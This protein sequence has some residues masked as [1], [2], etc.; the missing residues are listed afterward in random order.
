M[1]RFNRLKLKLLFNKLRF[2]L[3]FTIFLALCIIIYKDLN[4]KIIITT[5]NLLKTKTK[6]II[7]MATDKA[8]NDIFNDQNISLSSLYTTNYSINGELTQINVNTVVINKIC[9][10][11]SSNLSEIFNSDNSNSVDIPMLSLYNINIFNNV[12]PMLH[13]TISLIANANVTY[14][15][16]FSEAGINQTLF[17]LW[18]NIEVQLQT[19]NPLNN[20]IYYETRKIPLISTIING[21]VPTYVDN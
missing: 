1:I 20:Q 10:E 16:S 13:Q 4:N 5:D 3:F 19:N 7:S 9:T 21:N 2:L 18:L 6:T 8:I 14:D 17:E 12:G 15:Q 11:I